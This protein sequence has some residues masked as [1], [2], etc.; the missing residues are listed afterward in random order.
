MRDRPTLH[1]VAARAGVSRALV[2]IVMREAPGASDATRERVR[3]AANELGYRPDP[4][5]RMLRSQRTN[6]LGVVFTAGQ[7]FHA[8]LVDGVYRAA[9][10]RGYD[11]LLSCVTPHHD[12]RKAVRTLLD[13]RVEALVL[14]GPELPTR[15]LVELDTRLPVVAVARKARGVDVVRNNDVFGAGLAVEHLAGLG[16]TAITYLDGGRAP[17]AAERRKGYRTAASAAGVGATIVN[18]GSTERAGAAAATALLE[19][20]LPTA[21]FAFN[22]RCALGF[23]DVAIRAGVRVPHDVSVVGFDDSPLAGLTHVD[24]TTVGQDS[25]QLAD[26]A[27]GRAVERIDSTDARVDLVCEPKLVIRGST[28]APILMP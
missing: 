5:A 6:L 19:S 21:V 10:Q 20:P 22:D 23:I 3:Q 25:A 24:L 7:E 13:D 18:G 2:S 26:L 14:I 11:V 8:G 16:H 12:E 15:E 4:R 17:G 27:V 1:D 28:A 9:E